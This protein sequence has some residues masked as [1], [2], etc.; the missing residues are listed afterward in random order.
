MS[1]NMLEVQDLKMHFY[2]GHEGIIA[3]KKK[4]IYAVDGISFTLAKGE[5]L[6]LVGESGCGK[7]TVVRAVSQLY[8]PTAGKVLLEGKDL[9]KMSRTEMF[10]A[11]REMQLVFQD[12]YSSLDPRLTTA[13]IIAEPIQIYRKRGFLKMSD[14]EIDKQVEHL[15]EL[16][17]LSKFFK[18][19]FPHEFSGGQRQRIGI[20][21]ALALKPH[22][23]LADEP[24][25]AL[26]VSIQAQVLNLFK[27]IQKEMGLSYLFIAHDLAVIKYISDRIAVMYLGKIVET[28]DYKDLY[29]NPLHPYT[30]ALLSAVPIPDPDVE[31]KRKRIILKGDVPSPDVQRPGC[32]FYDRC[33]DHKDCCRQSQPA[34]VQPKGA[35]AGHKV[36]CFLFTE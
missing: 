8:K 36:A 25:S 7:S 35:S 27:D 9:T 1:N 33:P 13:E 23:I 28:G 4:Y 29:A 31:R 21:R 16:V 26:D 10:T 5:T 14:A 24:V 32:C 12:P 3:G 30:K 2:M 17:G 20:A 34:F 19:R 15:M 11:R 22:L 6:G 18:N